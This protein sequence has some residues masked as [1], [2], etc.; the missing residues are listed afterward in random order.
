MR[1]L[2][3]LDESSAST[4]AIEFLAHS[5]LVKDSSIRAL[6]VVDK[7]HGSADAPH[8]FQFAEQNLRALCQSVTVDSAIETGDVAH[9]IL[10]T[11]ASWKADLILLGTSEGTGIAR[12]L[13]GSVSQVVA[14]HASCPVLVGR[15]RTA[16]VAKNVLV[17]AD[18]SECSAGALEWLSEQSWAPEKNI[19][20]LSVVHP[21]PASYGFVDSVSRASEMLLQQ[22]YEELTRTHVIEHWCKKLA[23]ELG[24]NRVPHLI[25]VG[26]PSDTIAKAADAWPCGLLVVGSHGRSGIAKVL[27][28]SV[29]QKV[30]VKSSCAVAI[31]RGRKSTRF[32]T[33]EALAESAEL[34]KLLAEKPQSA[35]VTTSIVGTD[36]NG[37]FYC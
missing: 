26:D 20:V 10:N 34:K 1:L 8:F 35:N 27:L 18:D 3:C 16:D 25:A 30:A 14:E 32:D 36:F 12:L 19:L 23:G 28:G 6:H 5:G 33:A 21:L 15:A 17:A 31:V 7:N 4:Q 11:A 9:C 22:Q 37:L 24:R 2:I 29:S 13:L